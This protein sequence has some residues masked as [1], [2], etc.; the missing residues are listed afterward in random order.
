MEDLNAASLDDVKEWFKTY[1]GPANAVLVDRRRRRTAGR[2]WRRSKKYFGD[3]PPGPP[4]AQHDAVDRQAHRHAARQCCRTA[5]RRRGST[6]SGTSRRRDAEDEYLLDLAARRPLGREDLAPLQ[7]AGLRRPDRHRRLRLRRPARDRQP[8]HRRG[9]GQARRRPREGREGHGRGAGAGSST[10]GPTRG[11][12]RAR[13]DRVRRRLH[14]R[15]RAHRRLRRQ[16]R[17]P[18]HEPGLRRR[19]RR[20]QD[21]RSHVEQAATADDVQEARQG[22]GSPTASTS[23]RSIRSRSYA[24]RRQAASTARSCRSPAQPPV[25]KFPSRAGH[26]VQ[27]PEDRPRRARTAIPV[28]DFDLLLRRRLRRRP[29]RVARHRQPG[30]GH[31]GRGHE[32]ADR[33]EISDELAAAGRD[34]RHRSRLDTSSRLAVR[35]EGQPRRR[36]STL[37]R[38]RRS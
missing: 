20:L 2:R 28:V 35:A 29:G 34:A 24:S 37:Y 19:P 33:A 36:R 13:E 5:C 25:A 3:I 10:K 18:G 12:A 9:H 27:R 16:V 22:A 6:R 31:A 21:T 14:P 8:V 38:R 26:A 23:S 7:A 32:D 30:H 11:R 17:H 15:H 1:Y 4:V